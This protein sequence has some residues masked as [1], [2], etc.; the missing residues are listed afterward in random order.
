MC[1][2]RNEAA[3]VKNGQQTAVLVRQQE[4][5]CPLLP[6]VDMERLHG[7]RP[8]LVDWIVERAEEEGAWRRKE[9]E[10]ANGRIFAERILG[11]VLGAIIGLSGIIGG[12]VAIYMDSPWAGG[13]ISTASIGTLAVAFVRGKNRQ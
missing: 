2:K 10:K 7:F 11:Q 5:D 9:V 4:V 3:A 8:D 6:V 1:A 13:T 12:I